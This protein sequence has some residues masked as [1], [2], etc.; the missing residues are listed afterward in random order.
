MV[1]KFAVGDFYFVFQVLNGIQNG[2]QKII[3]E[4]KKIEIFKKN[5]SLQQNVSIFQ[6]YMQKY[7][8]NI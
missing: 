8:L 5:V 1:K 6:T 2:Q 3:S 7:A 4:N